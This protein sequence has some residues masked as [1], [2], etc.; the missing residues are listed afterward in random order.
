MGK[1]RAG[2]LG[3]KSFALALLIVCPV[4]SQ[5]F[6]ADLP[7][8]NPASS[9]IVPP[10]VSVPYSWT[11]FY[12]GLQLGGAWDNS[13]W[14]LFSQ[15]GSGFLYGGQLGFNYQFDQFVLS[16]EGDFSGST[17]KADSVCAA[18][19]GSNCRT[20]LDYL[21]SLRGR[22][23]AVVGSIM[24]YADGGVA[25]GGFRFAQTAGLIQSWDDTV[26][27]GWTVG[28]GIEYVLTDHIIGGIEYDYYG[29]PGETLSGGINPTTIPPRESVN[30]V[31]A[32][33]SYKF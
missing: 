15:T 2:V 8:P 5:V 32:K 14:R 23:G 28:A 22:V 30:S 6:S 13:T 4:I 31:V 21:A 27:I 11:G 17:L 33:A 3:M 12:G 29:F 1:I 20:T 10:V 24:A 18:V 16:A 25:F 9:P 7:Q 19:A 26:H